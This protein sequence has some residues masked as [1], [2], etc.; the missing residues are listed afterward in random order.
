MFS[1]VLKTEAPEATLYLKELTYQ[2]PA[3][4]GS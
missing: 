2:Q 1:F 4:I 3:R